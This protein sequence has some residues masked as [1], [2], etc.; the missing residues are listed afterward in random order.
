MDV[1]R[2]A[3]EQLER[4]LKRMKRKNSS[5][6]RRAYIIRDGDAEHFEIDSELHDD[7]HDLGEKIRVAVT[8]AT[9]GLDD[10]IRVKIDENKDSITHI[11]NMG[12]NLGAKIKAQIKPAIR[13]LKE[14]MKHMKEEL[15]EITVDL[16]NVSDDFDHDEAHDEDH[17]YYEDY[18]SGEY[19]SYESGKERR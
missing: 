1:K 4:D 13:E 14:N 16:E 15:R 9:A 6:K 8:S 2:T 11:S 19:R 17:D 3:E 12:K 18:D 7:L 10:I 5:K